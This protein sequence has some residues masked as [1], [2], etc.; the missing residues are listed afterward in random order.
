[1]KNKNLKPGDIILFSGQ[2]VI[3]NLIKIGTWS[4]W[5]HVG[6]MI[7]KGLVA[8]STTLSNIKDWIKNEN[9]EG[10]QIVPLEDRL[11]SYE[12][13]VSLR[14][15]KRPMESLDVCAM[16]DEFNKQHL[17]PYEKNTWEL[18][19]SGID[20]LPSTN[21]N[22][23]SVFCS[24]LVALLMDKGKIYR[25]PEKKYND[26]SPDNISKVCPEKYLK[27]EVLKK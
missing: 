13:K 8:E 9:V 27:L 15:L 19:K 16:I 10:V 7:S 26:Y 11:K 21:D 20:W 2:G 23:D 24:E 18:L 3:S 14:R 25:D 5:S 4:K 22:L 6:I 17:K 1:M 12:G